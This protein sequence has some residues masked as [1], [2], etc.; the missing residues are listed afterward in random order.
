[1][2]SDARS[3][4]AALAK[5]IISEVDVAL[6]VRSA[7]TKRDRILLQ[8]L[9]AAGLRVA[10][11][12]AVSWSDVLARDKGQVQITAAPLDSNETASE[13]VGTVQCMA[14]APNAPK[15]SCLWR[16]WPLKMSTLLGRRHLLRL[17]V[18]RLEGHPGEIE[19]AALA[20]VSRAPARL[21]HLNNQRAYPCAGQF[22][23]QSHRAGSNLASRRQHP[24]IANCRRWYSL[25]LCFGGINA[26][27]TAVGRVPTFLANS[28]AFNTSATPP[29]TTVC[30]GGT[31]RGS[32]PAHVPSGKHGALLASL[33]SSINAKPAWCEGGVG[34][35]YF[36]VVRKRRRAAAP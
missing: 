35:E 8:V 24:H 23:R 29:N 22:N 4:G 28:L 14:G 5:R 31:A 25:C 7:R 26:V 21:S 36:L 19:G 11:V 10:E 2:K 32:G 17:D 9:Y 15:D 34:Q 12:V 6:L 18:P 13:E 33:T 16:S 1:V 30:R 20:R 3:R 27:V